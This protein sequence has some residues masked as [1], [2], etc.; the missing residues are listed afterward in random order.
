MTTLALPY[1]SAT[2][3]T[4][5]AHCGGPSQGKDRFCCS[6]CAAA[7]HLVSGLGLEGYYGRRTLAADRPP[8]RPDAGATI[9]PTP[10]AEPS[11]EGSWTVDLAVHGLHCAACVWLI[12]SVLSRDPA[13]TQARLNATTARL[14]LGWSG[15]RA[16]AQELADRIAGLGYRIA[17]VAAADARADHDETRA[18]LHAM[19]VAG[20]AAANVMLLSVSVWAGAAGEMGAS[21]RGMLHWLSAAIAMPALLFA[22]RPFAQSAWVALRA[23][24]TNM[25]VPIT[26]GVTLATAVSLFETIQGGAHAYFESATMLLFFL[27]LG[28]Y[29]DRRARGQARSAVTHFLSLAR[30]PARRL[31]EDGGIEVVTP[32][33]LQLGDVL[34]VAS[35]ERLPADG[36]LVDGK[37]TIDTAL[38]TGEALPRPA[39]AGDLV[40]AGTINVGAPVRVR[41]TAL[42][43]RTLVGQIA[44]LVTRAEEGRAGYRSLADRVARRY[45]PTVHA[46]AALSFAGWILVGNADWR[47]A[48]LIAAAVLIITCPCA[49]ALAVPTSGLVAASRLARRGVLLKSA[50]ALERL[51]EVDTIV[52]DKTGTLTLGRPRLMAADGHGPDDLAEAARIAASSRHPLSRALVEAAAPASPA[53]GVVEHPGRGLSFGEIRLGSRDFCGILDT[54]ETTG[55]EL[56]LTRPGHAPAH[57]RFEDALRPD[58][59]EALTSLRQAGYRLV[60]LSGDRASSVSAIADCVGL[61]DWQSGL[62]PSAK[63]AWIERAQAAGARVL[64][65]GDGLNDAPALAAAHA[66][67]APALAADATSGTADAIFQA[68]SLSAVPLLLRTAK[69]ASA[70]ARQN[71]AFAL[72]YNVVA[73]PLAIAGLAT[74]LIAALAMSSSSLVVVGNALRLDGGENSK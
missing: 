18:L 36:V 38:V 35:G 50:T 42:G 72:A 5:C 28:R 74:P 53:Q 67:L 2:A 70:I 27:L 56:W 60:L 3:D 17:P 29:L 37:T 39:Q 49:L 52:F 30:A 16:K 40:H 8:P 24:H 32:E 62:L 26:I 23:G 25:D 55:P 7:Y 20:F 11:G 46:L 47:S 66:S 4:T 21:T 12:E 64:M 51:A 54:D 14:R 63:S 33:A 71:L 34:L 61:T 65:V 13:V 69:G 43:D 48:M 31:A 58:A 15:D 1:P 10:F 44:T 9:D 6:G 57:F 59:A 22:G 19:V 45:A 73:M 68:A 41:V